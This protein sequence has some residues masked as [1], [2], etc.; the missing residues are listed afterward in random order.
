MTVGALPTAWL[1]AALTIGAFSQLHVLLYPAAFAGVL[2]T[3]DVMQLGF[4]A[5]L[6]MALLVTRA[7]ELRWA[8]EADERRRRY[9][10]ADVTAAARSERLRLARDLHDG[11]VQQLLAVRREYEL[12]LSG[13]E[14]LCPPA[15]ASVQRVGA[16]LGEA[17]GEAR[18]T[19]DELRDGPSGETCLVDELTA[20]QRAFSERYGH[21]VDFRAD[22]A[23][24]TVCGPRADEI[25]RIVVEA[26][27]NVHRHADATN[28]RVS[29]TRAGDQLILTVVDN[30]RG[31][32][33]DHTPAGQGITGMRERA[34]LLGGRLAIHSAVGEGTQVRLFA[35]LSSADDQ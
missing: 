13:V 16:I 32:A 19:I 7:G 17:V 12:A 10:L 1:A 9:H 29:A 5:T 27:V 22:P 34:E 28:V 30:G 21:T 31:F 26:L 8:R 18:R 4:Y 3:A 11:V 25:V 15:V 24:S 33:A 6:F 14:A 2:T 23:L 35:P 20:R